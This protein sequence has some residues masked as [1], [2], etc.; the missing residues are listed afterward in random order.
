MGEKTM[1]A[2]VGQDRRNGFVQHIVLEL[3]G[4]DCIIPWRYRSFHARYT[5]GTTSVG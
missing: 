1:K 4:N 2:N 3:K 5:P